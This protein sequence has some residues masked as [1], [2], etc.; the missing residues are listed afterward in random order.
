MAQFDVYVNPQAATR[1]FV[2]YIVDVQ[3]GLIDALSTRLVIPLSRVGSGAKK[4]P[5]NLCPM[6]A[7]QGEDLALMAH[8]AAP[9]PA[10]L[11]RKP[12]ASI[13]HL[14]SDVTAALDAVI[15]GF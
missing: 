12:V 11:L 9:I 1:E 6:M 5:A 10:K 15:S 4:I 7:V 14:A 2:P 8:L 3:S 13:Q